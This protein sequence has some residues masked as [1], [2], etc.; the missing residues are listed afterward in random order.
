MISE[1]LAVANAVFAGTMAI[2]SFRD[3]RRFRSKSW[4]WIK[5]AHGLVGLYWCGL[6]IWVSLTPVG[7]YDSVWFGHV[8]VRPAYTITFAVMLTGAIL[9]SRQAK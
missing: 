3:W 5:I 1:V 6:Y 7:V 8:F 9:R 2:I 4:A